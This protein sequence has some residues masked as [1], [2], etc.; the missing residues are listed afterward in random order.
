MP[1]RKHTHMTTKNNHNGS[2]KNHNGKSFIVDPFGN[3]KQV[4]RD[5][6]ISKE[7]GELNTKAVENLISMFQKKDTIY[8][9]REV[10][11]YFSSLQISSTMDPNE[12]LGILDSI[13]SSKVGVQYEHGTG[14]FPMHNNVWVIGSLGSIWLDVMFKG[15]SYRIAFYNDNPPRVE[16]LIN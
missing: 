3:M 4:Q 8:T 13:S 1:K 6:Y 9:N 14:M 5:I 15:V 2:R 12:G 11:T 10:F 16:I 7:Q